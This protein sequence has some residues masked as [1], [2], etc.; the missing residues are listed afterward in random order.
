M[1]FT[2]K[3]VASDGYPPLFLR[4][5]GWSVSFL[6]SKSLN[7]G[8][9]LGLNVALRAQLPPLN[10]PVS[11]KCSSSVIVG[12]WYCPFIFIKEKGGL[13]NPKQQLKE[14]V[15]YKMSLEQQWEEIHSCRG[16]GNETVTVNTTVRREEGLLMGS[17]PTTGRRDDANSMMWFETKE[18]K[19]VQGG[20]TG[21]G[22]SIAIMEKM[23]WD[24]D[25]E[26]IRVDKDEIVERVF[27]CGNGG[28]WTF[29]LYILVERYVIRRMN[30]GLIFT[31]T[32]R[33]SHQFREKWA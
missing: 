7:L 29:A 15:Y 10:F 12:V 25:T 22:L 16:H 26:A 20:L 18:K 2:G 8:D 31:Y 28:E 21:I 33:H 17:E 9:A 14:S 30:G 23:R 19:S 5:E 32:F 1:Y 4:R 3:S 11:Q 24:Q 13:E 6:T 27:H